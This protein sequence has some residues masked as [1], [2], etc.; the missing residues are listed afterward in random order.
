MDEGPRDYN[1][2]PSCG[3]E[4]GLHDFNSTIE[5]LRTLW[6]ASGPRWRSTVDP[7]PPLWDPLLQLLNG[8]YLK[9]KAEPLEMASELAGSQLM[10]S[11]RIHKAQRK[12]RTWP[13][14]QPAEVD[15]NRSSETALLGQR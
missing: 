7:E 2:C 12:R 9:S 5:D 14:T 4:F 10:G 13:L 15:R 3:T 1:I 8:V 6:L 11:H